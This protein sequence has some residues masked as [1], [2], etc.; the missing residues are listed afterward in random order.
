MQV[1]EV[2]KWDYYNIGKRIVWIY[3]LIIIVVG[4]PADVSAALR[5]F[6]QP[7]LEERERH[8]LIIEGAEI[9]LKTVNDENNERNP[10]Y[11]DGS[12]RTNEIVNTSA[13]RQGTNEFVTTRAGRK[14]TNEFV[15]TRAGRKRTN[16]F[17]TTRA[18]R[19]GTNEFVTTRAG[20]K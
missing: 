17:V 4:R 16:E 8:G 18:G 19:E 15:T 7:A 5:L 14:M 2:L 13:G 11:V 10:Y 1:E 3:I 12:E 6:T 20:R 9:G